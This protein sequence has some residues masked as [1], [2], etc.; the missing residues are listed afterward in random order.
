MT[1]TFVTEN[2]SDHLKAALAM[3]NSRGFMEDAIAV[4]VYRPG[5][6]GT[7]ESFAGVGVFEC[8]RGRRAELH[9]GMADGRMPSLEIMQGLIGIA[10]HPKTLNLERV[11][12]RI[13]AQHIYALC[14]VIKIGFEVEYRDRN[15]LADGGDAIV[16]SLDRSAILHHKASAG[17]QTSPPEAGE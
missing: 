13:P 8:F 10:F 3:T 9:F 2:Q 6:N 15:C 17:P 16:V 4:A 7:G 5:E 12:A 14:A 1:T 11:L